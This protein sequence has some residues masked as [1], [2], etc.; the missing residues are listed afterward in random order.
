MASD[1][2]IGLSGILTAQRAMLIASHN[3]SNANTKGY[4]RQSS[5]PGRTQPY[6]HNRR[7]NWTRCRVGKDY[8]TQG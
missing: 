6:D 8:K 2:Q 4:T 3:I 5:L 1:L 7:H